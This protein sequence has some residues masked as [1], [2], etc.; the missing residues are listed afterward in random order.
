MTLEEYQGT[1]ALDKGS[2]QI[3]LM[4]T[5]K[6]VNNLIN[7]LENG[8]YFKNMDNQDQMIESAKN[9]LSELDKLSFNF[10]EV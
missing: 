4:G 6:V 5:Q 1:V 3:E 8:T 10:E 7:D 9:I 2:I